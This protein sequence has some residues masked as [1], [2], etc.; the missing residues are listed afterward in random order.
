MMNLKSKILKISYCYLFPNGMIVTFDE[1]L[2]QVPSLQGRFSEE[3]YRKIKEHAD[4]NTKWA[5]FS[6]EKD[7]ITL[8]YE[9]KL[10]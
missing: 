2:E 1:K 5:G 8:E 9:Q 4:V 3:L 6:N 7:Y 10:L